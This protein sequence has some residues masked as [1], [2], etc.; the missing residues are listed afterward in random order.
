VITKSCKQLLGGSA[1]KGAA[2]S[3]A[4][5]NPPPP[6]D[7]KNPAPST[8]PHATHP[9]AT[10]LTI[11]LACSSHAEWSAGPSVRPEEDGGRPSHKRSYCKRCLCLNGAR[12]RVHQAADGLV[13]R[14]RVGC[15]GQAPG[16]GQGAG[17]PTGRRS[18]DG[19]GLLQGPEQQG[20]VEGTI[21][22][23]RERASSGEDD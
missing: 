20:S 4:T 12:D 17:K 1:D 22:R 13:R 9:S 2:L 16:Q 3:P 11:H 5:N 14:G 18:E 19:G 15:C 7:P 8:P 10:P 21:H 23:S 6:L